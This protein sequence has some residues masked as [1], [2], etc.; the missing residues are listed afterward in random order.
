MG[1]LAPRYTKGLLNGS[2][3]NNDLHAALMRK[4]SVVEFEHHPSHET[5]KPGPVGN[6]GITP[7]R[8]P[9]DDGAA[10]FMATTYGSEGDGALSSHTQQSFNQGVY[11]LPDGTAV[12]LCTLN[13]VDP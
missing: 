1:Q 12:G 5:I 13:Q 7:L 6:Q 8:I 11:F 9:A 10:E 4:G 3:S 2:Q